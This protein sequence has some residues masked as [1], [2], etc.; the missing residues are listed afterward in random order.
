MNQIEWL[1]CHLLFLPLYYSPNLNPIKHVRSPLKNQ[2]RMM[3][4]QDELSLETAL[5]QV[6]KLISEI[7]S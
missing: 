1:L 7:V 4:D 6:M 3:L 5:G 2:I